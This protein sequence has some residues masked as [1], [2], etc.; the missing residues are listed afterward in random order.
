[1]N[2]PV[3][4]WR[5]SN[6]RPLTLNQGFSGCSLLVAFLGPGIRADTPP[7]GSVAVKVPSPPRDRAVTASL[8]DEASYWGGGAPRLTLR[9]TRLGGEGEVSAIGIGTCV[10]QGTFTR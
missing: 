10:F 1:M 4:S 2:T 7:T 8:L 5:E 6:P 9:V 3:W